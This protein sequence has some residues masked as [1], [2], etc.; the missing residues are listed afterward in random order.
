MA[1][2]EI[3]DEQMDEVEAD[4]QPEE[5]VEAAVEQEEG[6]EAEKSLEDK[7]KEVIDVQV[8]EIGSLRRKLTISVPR[9]T[10]DD[11]VNEQYDELRRE[12]VVPGFR[13]GRAP[14][15]LL[16]KR[17]GG[18][19]S[20]TLV[21]QLVST[22]YMA[23]V[24]KSD[25][26]V[27]GDPL[28][29]VKGEGEGEG[30]VLK[31]VQEAIEQLELPPD[32]PLVFSCEVEIRP[33][34]ELPSLE[35]I[36]LEKPIVEITDEDVTEQVNRI[37]G[38]QGT[39]EPVLEGAID[40]DDLVTADL[41]MTSDG[42]VVK[43]QADVRL[44]ARP[45]VVDGAVLDKLGEKLTG[46]K[47]GDTVIV[48]GTLGD[49]YPKSEFRGK[50]AQFEF[51]IKDIQR[52][53][54]PELTDEF[55]K[56]YGF[57][58]EKEL[59]D[60]LRQDLESRLDEE[61]RRGLRG[62]TAQYLLDNTSFDLPERLSNRQIAQVT[63]SRLLELYRRGVPQAEAE[64]HIDELRTSSREDAIRDLKLAFVMEKLAEE[65]EV[66]VSEGEINAMIAG[67]AQRQGQRFDR[68]RDHLA[69]QGGLTTLYVQIRD[70]KILDELIGKASITEAKLEDI[71][72]R[73]KSGEKKADEGED[74]AE[75]AKDASGEP[76]P[77][78]KVKRTPPKKKD[79]SDA[80]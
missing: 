3:R 60:F 42:T 56:A 66:E 8:E 44:A 36:P 70:D 14:R 26:K 76:K 16:E 75:A 5:E 27:L 19:V 31:D 78:E 32:G 49:D 48:D 2:D 24:E 25:L 21:Q 10:L 38:M 9:D 61:V 23:A 29:Y 45:Q 28:I 72:A 4:L 7:L 74:E 71:K 50:A 30:E 80:T 65:I 41:K 43:E 20:E 33:E 67:I 13:R 37:R 47:K 54:L 17:F 77:R 58:S 34:F 52:L 11:Q 1:D 53:K 35:S 68:V 46:A 64:K 73:K 15:R 39:Y 63:S 22:G 79:E 18:E 12:A 6:E 40:A 55:L 51:A 62:Q 59:R 57:D 69:Q